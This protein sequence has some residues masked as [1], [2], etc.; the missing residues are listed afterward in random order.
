MNV[1]WCRLGMI[2]YTCQVGWLTHLL[3]CHRYSNPS[4]QCVC[5]LCDDT[6]TVT[7]MLNMVGDMSGIDIVLSW[8]QY[9]DSVHIGY[10]VI[11]I[12]G[13]MLYIEGYN[14]IIS[15]CDSMHTEYDVTRTLCVMSYKE[16]VWYN[17]YPGFDDTNT[18]DVVLD[19]VGQMA[20]I[21]FVLPCVWYHI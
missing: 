2:S 17:W 6:D 18:V 19:I 12:L 15:C 5:L 9:G 10:D 14:V 8:K 1:I 20:D 16:W 4:I 13:V 7:V 21:T 3:W 11:Y